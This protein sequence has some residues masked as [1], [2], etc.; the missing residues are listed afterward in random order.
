VG[1]RLADFGVEAVD[2]FVG[3]IHG[4]NPQIRYSLRII[5][6]VR[7]CV[8]PVGGRGLDAGMAVATN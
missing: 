5:P 7:G 2:A 6:H 1:D 8:N 3:L 4:T